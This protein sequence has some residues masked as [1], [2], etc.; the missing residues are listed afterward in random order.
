[1]LNAGSSTTEGIISGMEEE[2]RQ[3]IR[4][5]EFYRSRRLM[6]GQCFQALYANRWKSMTHADQRL[7]IEQNNIYFTHPVF[8]RH[9]EEAEVYSKKE[10]RA[11]EKRGT[12][13]IGS[14]YRKRKDE[15]APSSAAKKVT[16]EKKGGSKE[17]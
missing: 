14:Y 1:M 11:Q 9:W 6:M 12:Y 17:G 10:E 3:L 4:K 15:E 8:R 13:D 16:G 7:A 5:G 2:R